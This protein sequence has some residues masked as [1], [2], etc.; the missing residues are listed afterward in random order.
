MCNDYLFTGPKAALAAVQKCLGLR[1]DDAHALGVRGFIHLKNRQWEKALSD[2]DL[3]LGSSPNSYLAA[4]GQAL[5]QELSGDYH[6]AFASFENLLARHQKGEAA[7]AGTEWQRIE[8]HLG[9]SRVL[10]QMGRK[11][12]AV[13]ARKKALEIDSRVTAYQEAHPPIVSKRKDED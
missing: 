2:F 6:L 8:A 1:H 3:G 7:V 10:T 9:C 13:A 12:D 11:D 4:F 5:A